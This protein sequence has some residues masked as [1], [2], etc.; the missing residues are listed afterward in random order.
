MRFFLLL[1]AAASAC[2]E[3]CV[4]QIYEQVAG[5]EASGGGWK[6]GD[7]AVY[8][9]MLYQGCMES[10]KAGG[11]C[12]GGFKFVNDAIDGIVAQ[13]ETKDLTRANVS[14]CMAGASKEDL[15]TV[16][17]WLDADAQ[18]ATKA[19]YEAILGA[20]A[21]QLAPGS[22]AAAKWAGLSD[23]DFTMALKVYKIVGAFWT[24]AVPAIEQ[25]FAGGDKGV[26]CIE[27]VAAAVGWTDGGDLAAA[28]A[29]KGE[30]AFGA[31]GL[32]SAAC[33]GDGSSADISGDFLQLDGT[34][35][36][37]EDLAAAATAMV[38]TEKAAVADVARLQAAA[39]GGGGDGS[40]A[41]P[42][43]VLSTFVA[44]IALML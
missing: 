36:K 33:F 10:V 6:D 8:G 34:Q 16:Q 22:L 20:V 12:E 11:T 41:S 40:A 21:N 31:D 39:P 38:D 32:G 2:D 13:C 17:E 4:T 14:A 43:A 28:I 3:Q 18:K 25:A 7:M 23:A 1:L 29:N 27:A 24:Y 44:V 35:G 15:D 30:E 37:F 5:A 19:Y 26:A 42:A 9:Y